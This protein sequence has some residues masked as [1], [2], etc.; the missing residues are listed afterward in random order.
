MADLTKNAILERVRDRAKQTEILDHKDK[1]IQTNQI[2]FFFKN[3]K[4]YQKFKMTKF[5][6]Y[7]RNGKR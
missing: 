2:F 3:S 1:K 5:K 4:F 7:L 6:C